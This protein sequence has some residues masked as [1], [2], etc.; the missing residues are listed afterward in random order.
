MRVVRRR[1]SNRVKS[2]PY[3]PTSVQQL[4]VGE[5]WPLYLV[6]NYFGCGLVVQ[7]DS[8]PECKTFLAAVLTYRSVEIP[9]EKTIASCRFIDQ[10]ATHLGAIVANGNQVLGI[11]DDLVNSI[12]PMTFRACACHHRSHLL[13]GLCKIRLQS[14]D[15]T[16]YPVLSYWSGSRVMNG[17]AERAFRMPRIP[18]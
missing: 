7:L 6:D 9:S 10:G 8:E 2:Y 11:C 1:D 3:S 15:D 5:Y 14:I 18:D 4:S 12:L 16:A 17:I 13:S